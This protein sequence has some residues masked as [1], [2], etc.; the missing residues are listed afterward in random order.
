MSEFRK[1][2]TKGLFWSFVDNSANQ[3]IQFVT[4]IILARL[5]TPREFGLIGMLTIFV[6]ISQSFIDSGFSSAL[7]R[8]KNCSQNDYSTIFYFNLL[9]AVLFCL[10][11]IA[12][13][14]SISKFFNEPQL[15]DLLIVLSLGLVINAFGIIQRTELTKR[16]DFNLQMRVSVI[17]AI[18]SGI[19][20]ITLAYR[21]YG[22][23]SLVAKT[24]S[25]YSITS[26]LLWLWNRWRP[27]MVFRINSL[28]ELFS[29]GSK[30]L[31]TGIINTFFQNLYLLVIGKV[32][33]AVD[34]G[35]FT[36]ADQFKSLPQQNLTK[37]IERVSFPL[38]SEIQDD[39]QKLKRSFRKLLR[40]SMFISFLL[41]FVLSAVSR[42]L[43]ITL[44][45]EKWIVSVGYLQWLCFAGVLYPMQSLNRNI[46]MVKNRSDLI[47]R[48]EIVKKFLFVPVILIGVIISLK[49]MIISLVM[50]GIIESFLDSYYSGRLVHY[51]LKSQV[52]D[53]LPFFFVGA[54]VGLITFAI[55]QV[56][57]HYEFIVLIIQ[58]I[59][60]FVT[61]IL[62]SEIFGIKEYMEYKQILK[63]KVT[64]SG[65]N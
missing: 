21:G 20:G 40:N 38:L 64:K 59:V 27:L 9:V 14:S 54:F 10:L 23:W 62:V 48:I 51:T 4:G 45:G 36:R 19:I 49:A 63:D 52:E 43:V 41:M 56:N 32:Y 42:T 50:Y 47:L 46:M 55:G 35:F 39:D 44:I 31:I 29:F 34:L 16:I 13:S 18:I 15:K 30:I 8:K 61:T 12:F 25:G 65:A 11:L 7:I 57:I 37:V 22:V 33:S 24:L 26:L 17:S 1:K 28:S 3:I 60:A 5:L 2:A 58:I 6:A 53:I